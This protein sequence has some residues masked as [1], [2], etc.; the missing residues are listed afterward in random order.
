MIRGLLYPEQGVINLAGDIKLARK[1]KK[2]GRKAVSA[3]ALEPT[4]VLA[5]TKPGRALV[6]APRAAKII[7]DV[8]E[9]TPGYY[10][11][12]IEVSH[13]KW[14]FSLIVSRLPA[15]PSAAKIVEMQATG[16]LQVQS[17]VTISF[18]PNLMPGLIRAL[19][20]QKERFEK[21]TKTELQEKTDESTVQ[22][23]SRKRNVRR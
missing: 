21:L 17:D 11:N 7:I 18:P 9:G 15:K 14:D 4:D 22:A 3:K 1:S 10:S 23:K 13:T 16:I 8:A 6:S 5:P 2:S 19:T 12:Y 20:T